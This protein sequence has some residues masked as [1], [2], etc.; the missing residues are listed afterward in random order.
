MNFLI[1]G[2]PTQPLQNPR[3]TYG[4]S[5]ALLCVNTPSHRAGDDEQIENAQ[6]R[7]N[8]ADLPIPRGVVFLFLFPAF[9]APLQVPLVINAYLKPEEISSGRGHADE[10]NGPRSV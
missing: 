2:L 1:R 8:T 4:L 7:M 6:E 3:T 5:S 9:P 10:T